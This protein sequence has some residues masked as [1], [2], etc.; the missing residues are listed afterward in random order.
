MDEL[1]VRRADDH[2]HDRDASRDEGLGLI[3]VERRRGDEVVVEALEPFGQVVEQCA[4]DLDRP[5]ELVT[6]PLGVVAGV[7]VGALRVQDADMGAGPLAL[8]GG[9]ER[10]RGQLVGGEAGLRGASQHLRHD[11]R[12]R[13]RAAPLRRPLGNM[14][15]GT[16]A[17]RDVAGIGQTT[18][19]R[20]DRIGVHSECRTKLAHG[21]QPRTRQQA[22]GVD[23]VGE[24]PVDL[25]RDRDI[26]IALDIE[27]TTGRR[28]HGTLITS[29]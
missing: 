22:T 2:R 27:R 10:G 6:Q 15:S 29:D 3:G 21:R 12:Q 1:D 23:L 28:R 7:G 5:A 19:D 26:R 9:G 14:R 17:T 24:L 8:G 11:A 16:V 18:I 25:G 13:F 4:F 20:P